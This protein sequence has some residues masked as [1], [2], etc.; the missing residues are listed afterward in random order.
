MAARRKIVII[1]AGPAGIA[2]GIYLQRGGWDPLLL[3]SETPGGLL[4]HANLV[5]NYPGFPG[6]IAGPQLANTFCRQLEDIGGRVTEA[7]VSLVSQEDRGF[8]TASSA[9]EFL[10]NAVIVATGTKPKKVVLK[11]LKKC[12]GGR[13]HYD[14]GELLAKS[15]ASER[16]VV[17]GGGDVAFDQG[18]NLRQR[19]YNVIVLC[20]SR[21]RCLRL[22]RERAEKNGVLVIEGSS[23]KMVSGGSEGL[24]FMLEGE[25]TID[26]HRL[27]VSCGREPC[28]DVLNPSLRAKMSSEAILGTGVPGLYLAGDVAAGSKR[29]VGIA[30]GSGI[31]AAM[32]AEFFLKGGTAD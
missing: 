21:A 5:E 17:Y 8:V 26:A 32:S 16:I 4:C 18:I 24:T 19:G 20:R 29:Q 23:I 11:G 31:Q 6:G 27:L 13:V 9:G 14:L 22:L 10:S 1:G 25:E 30:V 28:L 2:A 15:K 3:E 7:R 12:L